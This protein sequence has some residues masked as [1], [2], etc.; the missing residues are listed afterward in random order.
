MNYAALSIHVEKNKKIKM[1]DYKP[2]LKIKAYKLCND[3]YKS[4]VNI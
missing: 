1:A 3:I 2:H 4:C